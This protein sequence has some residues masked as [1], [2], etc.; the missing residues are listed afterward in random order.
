[1]LAVVASISLSACSSEETAD[2]RRVKTDTREAELE[3]RV[4][5][6]EAQIQREQ[7]SSE[8][9]QQIDKEVSDRRER[10]AW[11]A[12][13]WTSFEDMSGCGF[14]VIYRA[15]GTWTLPQTHSGTYKITAGKI[16][17]TP[18]SVERQPWITEQLRKGLKKPYTLYFK[19]IDDGPMRAKLEGK[20]WHTSYRCP[21]SQ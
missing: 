7:R 10:M 2:S 14:N 5:A 16:L 20:E 18:T 19:R 11:L 1:M 13:E 4:K 12:G 17:H 15:D 3:R 6:L 9:K 21:P 8:A